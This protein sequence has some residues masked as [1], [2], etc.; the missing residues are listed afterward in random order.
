MGRR[1]ASFGQVSR[2]SPEQQK[3][4]STMLGQVS[5]GLESP[6][7][8]SALRSDITQQPSYQAGQSALMDILQAGYQPEQIREAFQANVARP[9]IEQFQQ[10][11]APTIQQAAVGAGGGRSS[12]V[13]AQVAR[14]G[15]RLATNLAGQL[16]AQ[17]LQAEEM[18]KARQQAGV[19]QAMQYAQAPEAQRQQQLSQLAA[20]L[21]MGVSPSFQQTTLQPGRQGFGG[22]IGT[23]LG[24]AGGSYFGQPLLGAKIGGQIGSAF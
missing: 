13:P 16:G 21:G 12:M 18:A 10:E 24:A 22:A 14:S 5:Q 3:I 15:E 17:L 20:L 6:G 7:L 19:G 23:A 2:L 1:R 9:A 11:L 8:T 4:L